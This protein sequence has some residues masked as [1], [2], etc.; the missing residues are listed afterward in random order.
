MSSNATVDGRDELIP[1]GLTNNV[2][3]LAETADGAVK[4]ILLQGEH[5]ICQFDCYF[6]GGM[7]PTWKIIYLCTITFGL[8]GFV[9][10]YRA[11]MRACYSCRCLTPA[12][13]EFNRGKVE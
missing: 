11:M 10:L 13:I 1:A 2:T 9:L 5:I 6:P 8:Y 4:R 7:L 3:E 12:L